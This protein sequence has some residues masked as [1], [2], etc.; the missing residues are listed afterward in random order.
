METTKLK[1]FKIQTKDYKM[2][3][4]KY[5]LNGESGM[6]IEKG[7]FGKWFENFWYH[8]KWHT[9][10]ISFILLVVTVCTVQMCQKEEYD[11]H[12]IYAGS[13]YVSRVR[14]GG[15]L[16]EYEVLYKSINEAAEDFDGNGK[17][18]SS[19][20]AMFMLTTEEI[21]KIEAELD[22]K[23]NNGEEAEELNYAQLSENNR[24]FAE[25]IQY[26][27]VYVFLISEPLYHKYQREATDQSSS[28]FVP[29]RELAN[30]NTSL[31]F[32]DD[33]AVYLHS[34]EYG[35]LP[36]LCDL[37]EDT[38]ITLRAVGALS[39]MFD[40]EKTNENYENAKKVVANMLNYGS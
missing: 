17:V 31:V 2:R 35:K 14:D 40:K 36:G 30:K 34:T 18:H 4:E 33:S 27:D 22:E 32:L 1:T 10:F 11:T 7:R 13:E 5:D 23:K 9:I 26:S 24:A 38:Q 15:D 29:I 21:E 6:V 16:S 19:F 39:T 20:E 25:R 8:Y 28:L 3:E 12:I 37:P